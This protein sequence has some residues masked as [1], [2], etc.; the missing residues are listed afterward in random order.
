MQ[1]LNLYNGRQMFLQKATFSAGLPCTES[2]AP[3]SRL[4][5]YLLK[6]KKADEREDKAGELEIQ[7]KHGC[8]DKNSVEDGLESIRYKT[9]SQLGYLVDVLFDAIQLFA[10]RRG[11]VEIRRQ[12]VS[13]APRYQGACETQEFGPC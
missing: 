8:N 5:K 1:E 7:N 3:R 13:S 12:A 4:S 2:D 9:R 6:T 10:H 11:F